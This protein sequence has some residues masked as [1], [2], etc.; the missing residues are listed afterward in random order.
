MFHLRNYPTLSKRVGRGLHI[1]HTANSNLLL[2]VH[3]VSKVTQRK[4]IKRERGEKGMAKYIT[5]KI[6][7][8]VFIWNNLNITMCNESTG[9][10]EKKI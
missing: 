7:S 6:I 2:E 5:K 8:T 9:K 1:Q 10:K 4:K 3:S